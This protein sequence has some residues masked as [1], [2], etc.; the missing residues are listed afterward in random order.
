MRAEEVLV[1]PAAARCL[2]Y[3]DKSGLKTSMSFLYLRLAMSSKSAPPSISSRPGRT[4]NRT[5]Q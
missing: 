2:L 1:A 3:V 5:H 4:P